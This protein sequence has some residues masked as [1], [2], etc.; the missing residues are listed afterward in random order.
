MKKNWDEELY[1][2]FPELEFGEEDI[3]QYLKGHIKNQKGNK[4]W[5]EKDI[6]LRRKLIYMKMRRGLSRTR[7]V[8]ELMAK[9]GSS[10]KASQVYVKD[11]F[12]ELCA[13]EQSI[14]EDVR[15]TT[16]EKLQSIIEECLATG[17]RKEALAAYDQL[18]KINGLYTEKR[19]IK[20]NDIRFEF[21]G[22]DI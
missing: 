12:D 17:R 10:Q 13:E 14:K 5:H 11:A 4:T 6:Y 20:V 7:I 21:G 16:I 1:N 18:N 19:E 8:E 22:A 2:S 9:I 15:T 3:E